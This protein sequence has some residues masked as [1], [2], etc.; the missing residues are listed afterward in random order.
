[1]SYNV[2]TLFG[3]IP[4]NGEP[5]VWH[6]YGTRLTLGELDLYKIERIANAICANVAQVWIRQ[7]DG[8]FQLEHCYA[9]CV[10]Q[11]PIEGANVWV[12]CRA[13]RN[14]NEAELVLLPLT[15]LTLRSGVGKRETYLTLYN[16]P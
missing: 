1:M 10:M 6:N 13:E 14:Y 12:K 3:F 8:T 11:P 2:I 15:Q 5:G 9:Y 4:P 7:E 16:N